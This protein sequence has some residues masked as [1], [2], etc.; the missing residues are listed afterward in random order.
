MGSGASK[1]SRRLAKTVVSKNSLKRSNVDQLAQAP[2]KAPPQKA[3]ENVVKDGMDPD[4][5]NQQLG[6]RAMSLGAVQLETKELKLDQNNSAIRILR[7]RQKQDQMG[8]D[9]R[10]QL[11]NRRLLDP[12]TVTAVLTDFESGWL[13]EKVTEVYKL[14]PQYLDWLSPGVIRLAKGRD[15]S[16]KKN[17]R[18]HEFKNKKPEK[19]DLQDGLDKLLL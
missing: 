7:S 10:T 6:S 16:M 17:I 9:S 12:R 14:H 18:D 3:P 1:P 15:E 8:E 2:R 4:V 13:K 19:N 11:E 5:V